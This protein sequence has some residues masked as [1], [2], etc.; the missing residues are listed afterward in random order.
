[1]I[2][3]HI[4]ATVASLAPE[5][6]KGL[7]EQGWEGDGSAYDIGVYTGD[8]D[9]FADALGR[10]PTNE[11]QRALEAAVRVELDRRHEVSA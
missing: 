4:A 6:A 1:V 9:A 7:V 10:S 11:E 8:R 2:D 3:F 5:L